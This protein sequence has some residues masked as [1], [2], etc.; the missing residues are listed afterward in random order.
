MG[1]CAANCGEQGG[2]GAESGNEEMMDG[3]V[4]GG[5]D[6]GEKRPREGGSEDVMINEGEEVAANAGGGSS[7]E[8]GVG[9]CCEEEG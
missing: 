8:C 2:G 7:G 3:E 5:V 9:L 4:G 1:H 6:A